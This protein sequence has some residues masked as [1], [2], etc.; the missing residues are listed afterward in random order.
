VTFSGNLNSTATT[1]DVGSVTVVDNLGVSHNLTMTL[2]ADGA[3][4]WKVTLKDGATTFEGA[5]DLVFANGVP[6]AASAKV[7]VSYTPANGTAVPI[8]LD[9]SSNV[10]SFGGSE[11]LAF[12][13]QNSAAPSALT[14]ET[15]DAT[16]T[17][18]LSYANGQTAK[19]PQLALGRF[20]STDAVAAVGGNEFDAT[21]SLEW[22]TGSAQSAGFGSVRS[23]MVEL[24]NV[25]LSRE[26]SDLV[27]MQRGY[28]ASSQV[29]STANDMLQELMQMKSK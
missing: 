26:F 29:I 10:A 20:D 15:F 1:V 4:K 27:I 19:G 3:D 6:T 2:D 25:D 21:N 13:S 8:T 28:Q 14:G 11:T 7:S 12:A 23:G 24:S 16:G 18:V 9:F 22:H 5:A 17:L